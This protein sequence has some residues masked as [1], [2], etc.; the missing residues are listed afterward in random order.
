[1]NKNIKYINKIVTAK[2]DRPLGSTHSSKYPNHIYPVNYGCI[3]N[4]ISKDIFF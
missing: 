3:P 2:I 4:T 1:M